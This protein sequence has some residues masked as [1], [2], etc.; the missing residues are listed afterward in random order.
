MALLKLANDEEEVISNLS[1]NIAPLFSDSLP[2]G[3]YYNSIVG[4]VQ[5]KTRDKRKFDKLFVDDV[6]PGVLLMADV[7][8]CL[9]ALFNKKRVLEL[10]AGCGLPSIICAKLGAAQ[11]VISDYPDADVLSSIEQT[12]NLNNTPSFV[13]SVIPHIW[14]ERLHELIEP[15]QDQQ[16]LHYDLVILSEL[17][18]KDTYPH[19]RYRCS[20]EDRILTIISPSLFHA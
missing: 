17:L 13:T 3:H 9:P 1:F 8:C 19:H 15:I 6:W 18:W 4:S 20:H 5:V 7:L 14:G 10:G 16:S 11:V 12:I 2:F